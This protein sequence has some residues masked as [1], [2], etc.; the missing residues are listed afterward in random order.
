MKT[1]KNSIFIAIFILHF[2]ELNLNTFVFVPLTPEN[3]K[4]A[5]IENMR[6]LIRYMLITNLTVDTFLGG[7]SFNHRL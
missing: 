3:D 4:H 2:K 6:F 1:I 5:N 7:M